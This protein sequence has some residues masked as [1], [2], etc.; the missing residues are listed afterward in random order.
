MVKTFLR[1][2]LNE[3]IRIIV[4]GGVGAFIGIVSFALITIE[5]RKVRGQVLQFGD[6]K[7]IAFTSQEPNESTTHELAICKI[8][9][10]PFLWAY[11]GRDGEVKELAIADGF[12]SKNQIFKVN[13]SGL[14][15]G[16][17]HGLYGRPD[18]NQEFYIDLDFNGQFDVKS[19]L[20]PNGK[21][22][23]KIY[24]NGEWLLLDRF[25]K[26]SAF[27]NNRGYS[28]KE[29]VGWQLSSE[30]EIEQRD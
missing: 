16:W 1:R 23:R 2:T 30:T 5:L 24:Y 10:I 20:D 21:S 14:G 6:C 27:S 19:I 18:L 15:K 8:D 11:K 26:K 9:N 7:I 12:N 4:Y 29:K 3:I 28:F 13:S 22:I 17:T 25:S